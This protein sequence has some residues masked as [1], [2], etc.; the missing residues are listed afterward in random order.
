MQYLLPKLLLTI[1]ILIFPHSAINQK[2]NAEKL[3]DNIDIDKTIIQEIYKGLQINTLPYKVFELAYIGYSK[4]KD[5][6]LLA[7]PE[8]LTIIDYSKSSKEKR[9]FVIDLLAK[10]MLFN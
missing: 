1:F 8:I 4:L 5:Q 6:S 9:L 7:H 3:K 2:F 10:K